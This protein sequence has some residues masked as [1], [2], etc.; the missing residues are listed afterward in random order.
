MHLSYIIKK[1]TAIKMTQNV[2]EHERVTDTVGFD[3]TTQTRAL[4]LA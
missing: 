3:P 4:C 2:M 1:K